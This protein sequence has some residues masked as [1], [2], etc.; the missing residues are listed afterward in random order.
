MRFV[1]IKGVEQLEMQSLHRARHL[2]VTQR[3]AL[4]NQIRG[5]LAEYGL[6]IPPGI[7]HLKRRLPD[8]LADE[9]DELTTTLK[10]LFHELLGRF[11]AMS[12]QIR[13]Y[14]KQLDVFV[15]NN[16]VCQRLMAMEGMGSKTAS[17]LVAT[18]TDAS[19]FKN[20]RELAAW[21][22]LV[23]RQQ[24]SGGK[25]YLQGISKRGDRYIRT[26]LIH[27]ARAALT[28][29]RRQKTPPTSPRAR[30]ALSKLATLGHNKACVA[31]ANKMA[32]TAW[33]LLSSEVAYDKSFVSATV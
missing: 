5:L 12:L 25:A 18:V 4:S 22:G 8:I 17:I 29:W 10:P 1:P 15:K 13:E 3:T 24:S 21:L 9:S 20:G 27:G 23:P 26:L 28:S 11:N 6:V 30:W 33:V 32:R 16:E 19:L 2:L 14:D 7:H 31:L